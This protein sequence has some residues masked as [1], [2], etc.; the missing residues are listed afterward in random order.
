M[1]VGAF[2]EQYA[3]PKAATPVAEESAADAEE[4]SESRRKAQ[5]S[6]APETLEVKDL[7]A[8]LGDDETAWLIAAFKGGNNVQLVCGT[9]PAHCLKLRCGTSTVKSVYS[10]NLATGCTVLGTWSA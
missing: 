9:E 5:H 1:E 2:L 3:A 7:K 8:R 4:S 10:H 6:Y